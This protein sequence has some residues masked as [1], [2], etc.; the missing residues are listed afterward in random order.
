MKFEE[1]EAHWADI[2]AQKHYSIF[3]YNPENGKIG[4]YIGEVKGH[5]AEHAEHK[6]AQHL[7]C[8]PDTLY[9][10]RSWPDSDC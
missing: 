3:E 7:E 1:F 5:D 8:S 4:D 9:G 6:M 2:S 10:E